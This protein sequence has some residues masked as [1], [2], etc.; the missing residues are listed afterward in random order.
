MYTRSLRAHEEVYTLSNEQDKIAAMALRRHD[1]LLMAASA[2]GADLGQLLAS[3]DGLTDRQEKMIVSGVSPRKYVGFIRSAMDKHFKGKRVLEVG[4]GR[5]FIAQL[6]KVSGLDVTATDIKP[7]GDRR[8]S[9]VEEVDGA[10]AMERYANPDTVVLMI[11]P[12][13]KLRWVDDVLRLAWEKQVAGFIFIGY[14][15]PGCFTATESFYKTLEDK[16]NKVEVSS[17]D[18][19]WLG[20]EVYSQGMV[21]TPRLPHAA[22]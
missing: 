16:W 1:R 17:E 22:R 20:E 15:E 18:Y 4:C 8:C 12:A 10:T 6:L 13:P 19:T 7:R 3:A 5:G 21:Y 9:I 11:W 14:P 2:P